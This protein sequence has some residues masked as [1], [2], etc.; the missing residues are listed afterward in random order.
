MAILINNKFKAE[1]ES[2]A[3]GLSLPLRKGNNGY[4]ECNYETRKQIQDN[5][6]NLLF[7][8]LVQ[9]SLETFIQQDIEAALALYLPY[10]SVD[11]IEYNQIEDEH[12]LELQLNYTLNFD[13]IKDIQT[14]NL[15]I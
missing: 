4:F 13:T 8:P 15:V 6:K 10:V 9:D 3:I 11:S 7:E 1:R 2:K 12:K 5:I 14:I